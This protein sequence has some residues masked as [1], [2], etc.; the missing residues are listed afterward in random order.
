M[1]IFSQKNGANGRTLSCSN[2]AQDM[3]G[4]TEIYTNY[5]L[6]ST[7]EPPPSNVGLKA[8]E[9]S[10]SGHKSEKLPSKLLGTKS[11]REREWSEAISEMKG[12]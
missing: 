11:Q 2:A 3:Q 6:R 8:R 7:L 5:F 1:V 10:V 4:G 9:M 12:T